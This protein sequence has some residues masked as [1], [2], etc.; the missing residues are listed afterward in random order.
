MADLEQD[1]VFSVP[2]VLGTLEEVVEESPLQVHTIVRIE[3]GPVL[4]SV[5]LQPLTLRRRPQKTL[6]VSPKMKAAAA[7]VAA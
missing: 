5:D 1:R 3:L 7:P 2:P 4:N 6:D